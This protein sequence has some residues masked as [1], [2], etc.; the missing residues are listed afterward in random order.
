MR[1]ECPECKCVFSDDE[2]ICRDWRDPSN[3][4]IC[5]T[6]DVALSKPESHIQ[7]RHASGLDLAPSLRN[8]VWGLVRIAL[9]LVV[10]VMLLL[11]DQSMLTVVFSAVCFGAYI[12]FTWLASSKPAERPMKVVTFEACNKSNHAEL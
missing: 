12:A 1:F 2:A 11:K 7:N 10:P 9:L 8:I 4:F 6:C 3:S 5:P